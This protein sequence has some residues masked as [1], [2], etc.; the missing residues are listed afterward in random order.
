LEDRGGRAV[1]VT[2][3]AVIVTDGPVK[4]LTVEA[5]RAAIDCVSD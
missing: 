3:G 5:V 2:D 1:I 4:P